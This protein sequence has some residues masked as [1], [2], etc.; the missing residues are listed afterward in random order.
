LQPVAVIPSRDKL[1]GAGLPWELHPACALWPEMPP[2]DLQALSDNI[3]D[4]GLLEPIVL[5]PDGLCL[6]GRNRG[7]ACVMAG[8]EPRTEIYHGDPWAYSLSRNKY[9]RHMTVDKIAMVAAAMVTATHGGDRGNQHTGGKR[10]DGPLPLS[11]A[12]AAED[13]GVTKSAVKSAKAVLDHGTAEEIA[14]IQAGAKKV[15]PTADDVRARRRALPPLVPSKPKA[16][17]PAADPI[18]DVVREIVTQCADGEWRSLPKIATA[19]RRAEDAVL[20]ALKALGKLGVAERK[21]SESKHEYWIA[22]KGDA[23]LL[24]AIVA[25]DRRIAALEA[26]L[27][28]INAELDR[29]TAPAKAAAPATVMAN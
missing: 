25:K 22:G 13:A 17:K 24:S 1:S 20:K 28:E 18:D 5:T 19:V 11:V 9:R 16:A 15:R 14:A 10:P 26:E 2:A 12:K 23:A 3:A 8:V 4:H 7:L 29:A 6:D 21:N 27:A